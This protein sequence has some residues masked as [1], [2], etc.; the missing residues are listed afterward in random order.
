MTFAADPKRM[1]A[2]VG[3]TS[4]LHTRGSALTH[5]PH[6]HMIVPGGGLS[7]DGTRWVAC[8][9]GFLMP[10]VNLATAAPI[11]T[12]T[13]R[14]IRPFWEGV[15]LALAVASEAFQPRRTASLDD[16]RPSRSA[17]TATS[18]LLLRLRPDDSE[19]RTPLT[20]ED[21]NYISFTGSVGP[22]EGEITQ[23]T[24]GA[25]AFVR[26]EPIGMAITSDQSSRAL[27]M[28][29]DP[30]HARGRESYERRQV[31]CAKRRNCRRSER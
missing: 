7:P 5:H 1:G 26:G 22:G 29:A 13:G 6:I 20:M 27:F 9:P 23:G 14:M 19:D 12:G 25:F 24:S 2:R 15:D 3:M 10:R 16:L 4:V 21:R 31:P 18:A 28:R 11:V 30:V 17:Q 8:R